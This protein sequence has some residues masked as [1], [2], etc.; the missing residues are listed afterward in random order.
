MPYTPNGVVSSGFPID[1]FTFTY[2]LSGVTTE[3][4]AAAAA[5]KAVSQDITAPNTFK[6]AAD[7]DVIAGRVYVAE[8]RNV[9]GFTT[10]SIQRKF[11]ERM[12]TVAAHGIIVGDR[13]I[14]GG[15]GLVKKDVAAAVTNPRVVEVATDYVV[16]ELF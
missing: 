4:A 16:V 8:R 15:A 7:G 12:P 10:A 14:G 5:G 9:E 11:K 6:L 3:V 13:V 2:L 1:D